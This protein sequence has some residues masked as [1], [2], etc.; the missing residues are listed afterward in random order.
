[1]TPPFY[2]MVQQQLVKEPIFSFW[3]GRSEG[4][5]IG[6]ELTFGG[7]DSS[8]FEGQI[9]YAPVTRQGY[10]EVTMNK[11]LVNG[12]EI[13]GMANVR[14]AIDTGTSLIAAPSEIADQL[15]SIIGAQQGDQGTYTV[16]CSTRPS[17]PFIT[18]VFG[19]QNFSLSPNDYILETQGTCLSAFTGIDIPAPAGPLWIVGDAF[20][21]AWY[22][23]YDLGNNRVGF[24]K[25]K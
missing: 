20:L 9:R 13:S 23:V 1:V 7:V 10:W 19:G 8:K 16:D 11:L 15:N 12:T 14:A 5:V 22:T 17:L 24:A 4:D 3:I 18:F 25:S 6:G 2:N 21:R